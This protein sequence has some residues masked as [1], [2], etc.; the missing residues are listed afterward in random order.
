RDLNPAA[1]AILPP[2]AVGSSLSEVFPRLE[3]GVEHPIAIGGRQFDIQENPITDPRGTD[4]GHVFLLRD[5][6]AREERQAE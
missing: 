6:T 2:D 3:V 4:R 5:V 1:E